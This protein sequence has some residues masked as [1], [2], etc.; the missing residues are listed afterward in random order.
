MIESVSLRQLADEAGD[1][2]TRRL[3]EVFDEAVREREATAEDAVLSEVVLIV[4]ERID[5]PNHP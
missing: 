1:D 2:L 3:I 4:R 5:A